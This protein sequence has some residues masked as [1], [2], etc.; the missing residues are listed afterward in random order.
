[1]KTT[2]RTAFAGVA[3][4]G[5]AAVVLTAPTAAQAGTTDYACPDGKVCLYSG[6][7]GSGVQWVVPGCWNNP[8]P[9]WLQYVVRSAKAASNPALLSLYANN[10]AYDLVPGFKGDMPPEVTRTGVF[11][12]WVDCHH[13][14]SSEQNGSRSSSRPN[15]TVATSSIPQ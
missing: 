8:V 2:T 11:N 9:G 14:S 5:A 1:M 13:P 15:A 7:Y 3:A 6:Y 10:T 4:L 12:V